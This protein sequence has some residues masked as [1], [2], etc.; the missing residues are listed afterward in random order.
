MKRSP[1][2]AMMLA[3]YLR[4]V[5]AIIFGVIAILSPT[6]AYQIIGVTIG[7]YGLAYGGILGYQWFKKYQDLPNFQNQ[8]LIILLT[9]I[10]LGVILILMPLTVLKQTI[11]VLIMVALLAVSAYHLYF[12]RQQ[13]INPLTFKNYLLGIGALV[14]ALLVFFFINET[15]NLVMIALGA[16]LIIYGGYRLLMGFTKIR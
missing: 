6:F 3:P 12:V 10:A 5:L 16:F 4:E 8:N 1:Q 14:G 13:Y 2:G 11:A 7:I 15:S 9:A